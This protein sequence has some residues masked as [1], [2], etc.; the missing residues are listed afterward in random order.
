MIRKLL[1]VLVI[2]LAVAGGLYGGDV[3][4]QSQ[5]PEEAAQDDG[6]GGATDKQTGGHDAPA[7]DAHATPAKS[8]GKAD[9][10][11]AAGP[12]Q[13]SYYRFPSQFFVPV[14]HGDRLDGMMVLTLTVEMPAEVQEDVF[15]KEFRLR[16][17]FLR[18][19][20]IHANTGGF[21]GN[22]TI[23]PRMRRLRDALMETATEVSGGLVTE[24][25]IEDIARQDAA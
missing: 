16:D 22:F 18:T 7:P 25:L 6:G 14:M 23:E 1:P 19:L 15:K 21:D 24:V 11:G 12:S 5:T 9:G 8:A 17:A 20:L 13:M 3:V 10:H 2:L 4:R